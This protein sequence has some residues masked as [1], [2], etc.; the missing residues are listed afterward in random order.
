MDKYKP[1]SSLQVALTGIVF[2][3]F[4]VLGTGT[5]GVAMGQFIENLEQC[6]EVFV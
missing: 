1:H 6:V 2:D 3:F 5:L 4:G